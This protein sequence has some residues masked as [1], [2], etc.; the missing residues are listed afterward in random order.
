[1]IYNIP[2]FINVIINLY[3]YKKVSICY[4][5]VVNYILFNISLIYWGVYH[6]KII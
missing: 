1:M 2:I 4:Y 3:K 6:E 5:F